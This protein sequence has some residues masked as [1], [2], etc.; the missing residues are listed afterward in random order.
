MRRLAPMLL[1]VGALAACDG[2]DTSAQPLQGTLFIEVLDT[3]DVQIDA[4]AGDAMKLTITSHADFG[5]VPRDTPL[6]ADGFVEKLPETGDTL[7]VAKIAAPADPGG[8]CQSEPISLAL[9]LHRQGDNATVFGGISAYCGADRWYGTPVRVLR[10][11][12]PLPLPR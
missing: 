9:S 12:G 8:P 6:E 2:D 7:Y 1:V 4:L 5:L 3:A 11:T 10:M